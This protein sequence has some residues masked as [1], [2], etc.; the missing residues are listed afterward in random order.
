LRQPPDNERPEEKARMAWCDDARTFRH[1]ARY[2]NAYAAWKDG[3][4]AAEQGWTVEAMAQAPPRVAVGTTIRNAVL[5]G[6]ISL[7]G[8]HRAH[9]SGVVTV[10]Y[11]RDPA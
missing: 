8:G 7:L 2:K 10:I 3:R 6:G 5:T 9:K 1:T 4:A 11:V